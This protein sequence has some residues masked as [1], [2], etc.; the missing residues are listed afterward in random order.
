M[1]TAQQLAQNALSTQSRTAY[2]RSWNLLTQFCMASFLPTELPVSPATIALFIAHLYHARYAPASVVSILSAIGYVHKLKGFEDPSSVFLIQKM[3]QGYRKEGCGSDN[4]LPIDKAILGRLMCSL[5]FTCPSPQ[6]TRLYQAMFSLAFHAFLRVG[7]MTAQSQSKQNP[8]LLQVDQLSLGHTSLVVSFSSYKHSQGQT[9]NLTVQGNSS[10]LACPVKA[11][12]EFLKDRGNGSGPLF[13]LS[14]GKPITRSQFNDNLRKALSFCKLSKVT[15][16]AHSF[17][18]G[19]ATTA[20]AQGLSDSQIRQ[21][22][23]WKSDAF[24]K[25][26]RCSERYSAL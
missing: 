15:F 13:C 19:A 4:R 16:K 5:P 21:L 9:F 26:I 18:I 14:P 1:G 25:Y 12:R 7:E 11:M 20:A 8:H 2:S 22:G 3:V 17:R 23:R 10:S 24:K 6:I